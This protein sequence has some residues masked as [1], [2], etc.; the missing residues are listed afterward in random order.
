MV[1]PLFTPPI[2]PSPL[3][4]SPI[5]P[6]PLPLCAQSS[7]TANR[8]I[9]SDITN[10]TTTIFLNINTVIQTNNHNQQSTIIPRPSKHQA[11]FQLQEDRKSITETP[12][13]AP[14]DIYISIKCKH[15]KARHHLKRS[16]A[17]LL[18]KQTKKVTQH[19]LHTNTTTSLIP[20][21]TPTTLHHPSNSSLKQTSTL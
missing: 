8:S 11:T 18:K 9:T 20:T 12:H 19:Y 5:T 3:S 13:S 21:S 17:T 7:N 14:I 2:S 10:H 4:S 1:L 15:I 16:S 6:T